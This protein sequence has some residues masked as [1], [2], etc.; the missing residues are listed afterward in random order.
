[1]S[2]GFLCSFGLCLAS[3][4][5]GRTIKRLAATCCFSSCFSCLVGRFLVNLCIHNRKNTMSI[6]K[7]CNDPPTPIFQCPM[8]VNSRDIKRL[9][10]NS[11]LT[12]RAVIGEPETG[13]E[14]LVHQMQQ[15]QK[16]RQRMDLRV[17]AVSGMVAGAF[18]VV[19]R[20]LS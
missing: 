3:G 11:D 18:W 15:L 4:Q 7:D 6:P 12:M 1:L 10:S 13:Q 20:L 14:G 5:T 2:T 16:W 17:A 8:G 19:E 9:L